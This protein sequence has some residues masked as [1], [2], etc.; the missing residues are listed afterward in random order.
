[1]TSEKQKKEEKTNYCEFVLLKSDFKKVLS[2]H[3]NFAILKGSDND[4]FGLINFKVSESTLKLTTTDGNQLFQSELE[5][6][7]QYGENAEFN[8]SM[9]QLAKCTLI[10]SDIDTVKIIYEN[11]KATVLD[12]NFN[13]SQI[14]PAYQNINYP[15]TESIFPKK[16][17]EQYE[18]FP[19]AVKNLSKI[20]SS[21]KNFIFNLSPGDKKLIVETNS[22]GLNQKALFCFQN[23]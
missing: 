18:I 19:S 6:L 10:K 3:K 5:I 22:D 17:T 9:K 14:Y 4:V 2:T 12:E 15:N 7:E 11:K 23:T 21:K 16:T 20:K 13:T 1:M 8:L